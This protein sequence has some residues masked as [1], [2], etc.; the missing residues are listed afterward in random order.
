MFVSQSNCEN[1][2][3]EL[4]EI[5][6]L[7]SCDSVTK[8]VS[9]EIVTR[10]PDNR[11]TPPEVDKSPGMESPHRLYSG[12][13]LSAGSLFEASNLDRNG[14][15]RWSS[16]VEILSTTSKNSSTSLGTSCRAGTSVE[17]SSVNRNGSKCWSSAVEISSTTSKSSG[18]SS[19]NMVPASPSCTSTSSQSE[20]CDDLSEKHFRQIPV[21]SPSSPASSVFGGSL[22][23][24]LLHRSGVFAG[25]LSAAEYNRDLSESSKPAGV[26]AAGLPPLNSQVLPEISEGSGILGHRPPQN[27]KDLTEGHTARVGISAERLPQSSKYLAESRTTQAPP[28]RFTYLTPPASQ[29]LYPT[30]YRPGLGYHEAAATAALFYNQLAAVHHL[31]QRQQRLFLGAQNQLMMTSEGHAHSALHGQAESAGL[32]R[33]QQADHAK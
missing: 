3:E 1:S 4:I 9:E 5:G 19:Q 25:D 6:S 21:T 29:T 22:K 26:F 16:A 17:A 24:R 11:R 33:I 10:H 32:V 8:T 15:E 12:T 7:S 28:S 2:S 31:Q 13:P 20:T 14:S 27:S 23:S 30:L 18:R